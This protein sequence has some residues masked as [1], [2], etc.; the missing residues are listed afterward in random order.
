DIQLAGRN[1][2]ALL[3]RDNLTVGTQVYFNGRV[4]GSNVTLDVFGSS[5]GNPFYLASGSNDLTGVI[6]LNANAVLE[7][8]GPGSVGVNTG[9]VTVNLAGANSRLFLRHYQNGDFRTNV[10]VSNDAEINAD[11]LVNYGGGAS[12]LLSINNLTV[13]GS[14]RTLTIGGGNAYITRVAGTATFNGN[15][16]VNATNNILF[17]NGITFAGGADTLDKRG[18]GSIILR[19]ASNHTGATIVQ[20]GILLLQ[21]ANGALPNSSSIELRG[22][23]LR[24]DN[25]EA[26]NTN[27]I[28][29]AGNLVLGGGTLRITGTETLPTVTAAAGTTVVINNPT[30]DSTAT[31]L[32]LTGFTRKLGAV[33]QFQV[34]DYGGAVGSAT[35][36]QARVSSRITIPGLANT[37]QTIPG[38][39]GNNNL[40]FIQYDGTTMDNGAVLGVRDMRNPTSPNSPSNYTNEPAETAWNDSVIA[41]LTAP[42]DNAAAVTTLTANR[43]LDA[44]KFEPGGTG[45]TRQIDLGAFQ[46]R[47][48]GGG[49]LAVAGTT[50]TVNINGTTGSLTAGLAAPGAG[51]NTAEL[52]I[53]GNQTININAAIKDNSTQPVALVKTG[54]ATLSLAGNNTYTGGTFVTSGT[55]NLTSNAA[56]GAPANPVSLSGGTLLF[57]VTNEGTDVALGGLGQDIAVHANSNIVADNGATATLDNNLALGGLTISGPYTLGMR[58]HDSVDLKFTGTHSFA[59]MPTLDLVQAGSGSNPNTAATATVVTLDGGITGSGFYIRS[60]GD[61][62]DTAARLQIGAGEAVDNTYT[63]KVTVLTGTNND[64]LFIE[65]NKAPGSTAITGDLQLDGG[66]VLSNANDQIADASNLLINRGVINFNGK[67]ENIASVTMAGGGLITNP[68]TGSQPSNTINIAG[69]VEVT[70][71]SNFAGVSTGFTIGN[72]STVTVGGLLRIGTFGRVHL[73]EGQAGSFLNVNGGLEMTG[74]TLHQNNGAGANTVRLNSDVTTLAS[75]STSNI[76]NSTDSDTFLELGGTRAF[77]VA[78][79]GAGIDL[80]VST[81]IRDGSALSTLVKNGDG[82]MQLQGGGTANSYTGGTTINAGSLILF[83]STNVNAIPAGMVTIGDG[84]GGVRADQLIVRNSNQIADLAEVTLA[85]SGL[86]DFAI[87]NTSETF[88]SL[89]GAGA[90]DLGPDTIVTINGD[91]DTVFSGSIKGGGSLVKN[92]NSALELAGVNDLAGGTLVSGAGSLVVSGSIGGSVA[93]DFGATLRG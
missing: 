31:A 17:E 79:G 74:A 14:N 25:S 24:V 80:S 71:Y 93:V 18:G 39:I 4:S 46:L 34:P 44:I 60:S 6:N 53:G 83:K 91:T 3:E 81:V 55:L 29:D 62:N 28:N 47:I 78:D 63:G 85:S 19:G 37:T 59:G 70:G 5:N 66:T 43:S 50:S 33:V 51:A 65:L 61:T 10:V 82:V 35:F 12:Q 21:G 49:I 22:G 84:N 15:T 90:V 8:R 45:R 23:E 73:A 64:D 16:I 86:L 27:R 7:A 1:T 9:D 72:N 92:G 88:A 67:N 42:T 13:N 26:I 11:R 75:P 87:F 41:R 20:Q 56:L 77:N 68:T 58:G 2:I 32:N 38:F 57:N 40:D 52:F 30:S 54:T 36:G 48:E 69:N 76:G 89:A